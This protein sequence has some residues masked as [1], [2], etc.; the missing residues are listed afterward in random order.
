MRRLHIVQGGIE[1][2]DKAWLE[3]AARNRLAARSWIAPK[4]AAI[5]DDVVIYVG[6]YGFFATARITSVPQVRSDWVNRYGANLGSIRLITPPISLG[7]IRRHLLE[8]DWA[9]YPRSITT[10]APRVATQIRELIQE[11]RRTRTPDLDDD[12]LAAASIDELRAVAI[13]KARPFLTPKKSTILYRA[14]CEAI[15]RYVLCRASGFC[16]SC[17]DP[18]PFASANGS[19]YLEPH[20]TTRLADDGPDHP[21]RV[22]GLCPNCHRR[23]HYADDAVAF[24]KRLIRRTTELERR[25]DR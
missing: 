7:T 23:A 13:L 15:R 16:E 4:T 3:R 2:G 9:I 14:R 22:I 8:L 18:A 25:Y 17:G 6:G 19:P 11:R 20:H 21:E 10:P 1:N 24:N 5:G 12:A